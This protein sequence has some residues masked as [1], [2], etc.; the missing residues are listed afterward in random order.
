MLL[1]SFIEDDFLVS[2]SGGSLDHYFILILRDQGRAKE[3]FLRRRR[4]DRLPTIPDSLGHSGSLIR[5]SN[6]DIFFVI[7]CCGPL[8]DE[9]VS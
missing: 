9:D 5:S 1:F 6:E 3:S 8:D 4:M 7:N 2:N